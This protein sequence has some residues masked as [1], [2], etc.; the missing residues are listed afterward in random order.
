MKSNFLDV[1]TDCPQRNERMGWT[2]DAQIFGRTAAYLMD[3]YPFFEKW[4]I[5]LAADQTEEGGVPHMV[6]DIITPNIHKKEDW[7]LSQGTHS[8]AAWADAA[9][10]NPWYLYLT[11][12]DRQILRD[13]YDSMKAWIDFM[14]PM[15]SRASGTTGCSSETGWPWMQRRAAISAQPQ[16]I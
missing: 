16:M 14:R 11:Y 15:P 9:V 13:Q 1:P 10:L 7:L 6:P 4:L 12:G 5:D 3:V 8:A 2:G